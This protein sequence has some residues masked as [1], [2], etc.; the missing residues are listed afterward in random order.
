MLLRVNYNVLGDF[1]SWICKITLRSRVTSDLLTSEA[2]CQS[3]RLFR[4]IS[5]GI[6]ISTQ[7]SR[8]VEGDG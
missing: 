3:L 6:Y 5:C 8:I 7:L 4:R 1:D 2:C